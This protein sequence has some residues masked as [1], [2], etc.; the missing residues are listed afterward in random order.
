MKTQA[1]KMFA[2]M[3]H[4]TGNGYIGRKEITKDV[5]M[6]ADLRYLLSGRPNVPEV[7]LFS[8]F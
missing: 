2:L 1:L 5:V 3:T 7:N 6:D 4:G 8:F